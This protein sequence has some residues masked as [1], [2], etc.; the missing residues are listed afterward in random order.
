MRLGLGTSP[1]PLDDFLLMLLFC[2]AARP[3]NKIKQNTSSFCKP[4]HWCGNLPPPWATTEARQQV[5]LD[6]RKKSVAVHMHNGNRGLLETG[7]FIGVVK[8]KLI[9]NGV[10]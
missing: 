3:T 5:G 4:V 7:A 1:G 2:G 8:Q 10:L 6:L 9:G